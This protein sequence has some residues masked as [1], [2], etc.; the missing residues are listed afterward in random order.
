MNKVFLLL[1]VLSIGA[2][3]ISLIK[4]S[5]LKLKSRKKGIWVSVV[6]IIVFFML[7]GVTSPPLP[8]KDITPSVA[9]NTFD[10]NSIAPD[11][12]IDTGTPVKTNTISQT[13]SPAVSPNSNSPVIV[14]NKNNR[15]GPDGIYPNLTL[16]PG[17][18]LTTDTSQV[19]TSGYSSSVRNVPLSEKKQVYAEYGVSY[20]QP[21]GA[22]EVDHLISL[23]LGGSNDIKNLFLEAAEPRPGFHEK[24]KVEN[25]LHSQVCSGKMTIQEAQKGIVDDWYKYYLIITPGQSAPTSTIPAPKSSTTNP[26]TTNTPTSGPQVKKSTS[27]LCHEKGTQ[28]Y[29]KTQQYTSYDSIDAC[30]ASGGRLPK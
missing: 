12:Q 19:C 13:S 9:T 28:Y 20:P 30:L 26:T 25:Y 24:D 18:V 21:E 23:E 29:D 14:S 1:L 15:T 27:G 22:Y 7:V 16:S 17:D 5:L 10:Q 2:L 6:G 11:Q 3:F 4:P 8:P